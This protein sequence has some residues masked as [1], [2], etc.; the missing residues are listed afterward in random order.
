MKHKHIFLI[1]SIAFILP[2]LTL[3]ACNAK[4]EKLGR[5]KKFPES[6]AIQAIQAQ[7]KQ[8]KREFIIAK[9]KLR[10][11]KYEKMLNDH[12]NYAWIEDGDVQHRWK[13]Y[14]PGG[15]QYGMHRANL[16]RN[17]FFI[18]LSPYN[19]NLTYG[20]PE[21][22]DARSKIYLAFEYNEN[23]I[24]DFGE[25]LWSLGGRAATFHHGGLGIRNPNEYNKL[26]QEIADKT[27]EYACNYFEVAFGELIKKQNN[28]NSLSYDML[29]ALDQKFDKLIAEREM[30]IKDA[31]TIY[32]DLKA[33]KGEI[34]KDKNAAKLKDYLIKHKPKFENSFEVVKTLAR[35]IKNILDTI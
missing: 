3:V 10:V 26:V 16:A 13:N 25:V 9:L 5:D 21:S 27:G 14:G 35:E 7:I 20:A 22:K 24:E 33:N 17:I 12:I 8:H 30:H 4:P 31:K 32:N 34:K 6:P 19:R 2:L 11:P 28:L 18:I 23:L 1:L 29:Q 15:R